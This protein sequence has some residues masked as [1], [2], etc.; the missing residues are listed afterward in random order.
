MAESTT[1]DKDQRVSHRLTSSEGARERTNKWADDQLRRW[2]EGTVS[3]PEEKFSKSQGTEKS[4]EGPP[5]EGGACG[6][7]PE[8]KGLYLAGE[9]KKEKLVAD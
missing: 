5:S 3:D 2:K 8:S 1:P 6:K 9:S 7:K 4:L